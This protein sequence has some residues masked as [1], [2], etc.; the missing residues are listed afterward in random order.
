[1]RK[2][3]RPTVIALAV[4]GSL[5]IPLAAQQ[6]AFEITSVKRNVSASG[7]SSN[8]NLA[9]GS[10]SGTNVTLRS[11]IARAYE[12]RAFQV[13]GGPQWLDFDRFDI[14]G[15][16]AEGTT[17]EM[18]PAMLRSLLADRFKLVTHRES[19]EQPVYA[20]VLARSDG[21]L[22]PQLK[23]AALAC[24]AAGTQAVAGQSAACGVDTSV[25]GRTGTMTITGMPLDA[26]AAAL[27]NFAGNRAVINRTGLEGSYDVELRFA[28]EGAALAASS[29]N[30][31]APAI[32]TAVEEQLGLK[33]QSDRGPVPFLVIDSV[34]PPSPD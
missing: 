16:G 19:R 10:Y 23:R 3:S 24:A 31:D 6:A 12:V 25:N 20:L 7:N 33:L 28:P 11:L 34:Q 30:D 13:T 17:N 26:V 8:R 18:R 15:R 27:A 9:N 2:A 14:V 29:R 22:G 1:M 21:R 5:A 32:F 4:L